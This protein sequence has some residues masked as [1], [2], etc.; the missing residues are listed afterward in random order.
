MPEVQAE[1]ATYYVGYVFAYDYA[2]R[3]CSYNQ[4][5]SNSV[6]NLNAD[7]PTTDYEGNPVTFEKGAGGCMGVVVWWAEGVCVHAGEETRFPCFVQN[8]AGIYCVQGEAMLTYPDYSEEGT[9]SSP[10]TIVIG[11]WMERL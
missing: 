1:L 4:L 3:E 2:A 11:A 7:T 10:V 9:K 6:P 5:Y 8:G